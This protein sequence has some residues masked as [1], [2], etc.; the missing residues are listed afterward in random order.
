[1]NARAEQPR[2]TL[3]QLEFVLFSW[4]DTFPVE[5][6]GE[7]LT[8]CLHELLIVLTSLNFP[9][10]VECHGCACRRAALQGRGSA[11]GIYVLPYLESKLQDDAEE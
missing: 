8:Q 1:M 6:I 4:R 7:S 9:G 11:Q 5:G 10:A 2:V 3:R